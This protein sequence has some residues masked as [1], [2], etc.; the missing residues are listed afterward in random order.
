VTT[1]GV[2]AEEVRPGRLLITIEGEVDLANAA[3]VGE[4]LAAV[5]TNRTRSVS[6]DLSGLDYLDSAGLR[7]LFALVDRLD[8]LQI[9]LEVVLSAASPARRAVELSGLGAVVAVRTS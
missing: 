2:H 5:I 9:E 8:L 6:I 1:A 4:Q 7:V 3:S